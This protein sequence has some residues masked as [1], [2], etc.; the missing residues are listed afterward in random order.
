MLTLEKVLRGIDYREKVYLDFYEEEVEVRPLSDAE[1]AEARRKSGIIKVATALEKAQA[2]GVTEEDMANIDLVAVDSS[3]A[4]L[5]LAIAEVGLVDPLLRN[6]VSSLMGG[7]I[8]IIGEAII[9]LTTA[10]RNEILNFSMEK[11]DK[12]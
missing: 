1:F 12:E 10:A 3:V 5:H 4:A 9:K 2:S 8:Q 6:N 11:K 7:S